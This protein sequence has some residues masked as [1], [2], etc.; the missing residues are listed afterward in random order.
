MFVH[1]L[2]MAGLFE[3]LWFGVTGSAQTTPTPLT[4]APGVYRV[5]D[6]VKRGLTKAPESRGDFATTAISDWATGRVIALSFKTIETHTD[7]A[8][9]LYILEGHAKF[10]IGK[11]TLEAGPG[12]VVVM[13]PNVAHKFEAI[14]DEAVKSLLVNVAGVS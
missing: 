12:D 13:P 11:D 14:G 10:T 7:H 1:A 2:A 6:A 9:V 4:T 5:D 3:V 8:H